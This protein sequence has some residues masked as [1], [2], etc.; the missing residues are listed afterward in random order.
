ELGLAG[1]SLIFRDQWR[2]FWRRVLRTGRVKFY[3]SVLA[4]LGWIAAGAL[5]DR[6]SRAAGELAAGQTA[7]L[8]RLLLGLCLLWLVGLGENLNVSL[9]SERL[10]RFSISVRSLLGL[11]LSSLFLSPIVWLA[12][13]VSLL[14][15]SALLSSRHSLLGLLAAL[16][17]FALTI[18]VRLC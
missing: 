5:P 16:V 10:R 15:L 4:L 7:S 14:G 1:A 2:A 18:G 9:S 11:E 8:D 13:I 3:L 6:L 12:T 17:F